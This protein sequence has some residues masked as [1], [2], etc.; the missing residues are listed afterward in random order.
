MAAVPEQFEGFVIKDTKNWST[1]TKEKVCQ[2]S[3]F[4]TS[5]DNQQF[6]PKV[7]EEHDVDIQ[8]E[9]C[10]VCGSDVHTITGGWGDLPTSPICVGHE[11]IGKVLRVGSKVTT[12]KAGDRVGVGAQIQSCM[13]CKNCKEHNENYCPHK[14][15]MLSLSP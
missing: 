3:H 9:V 8:S 7:F 15:G 13:K 1:F 10:G 11:V 14:V 4:L 12:C 2:T 5:S 6:T